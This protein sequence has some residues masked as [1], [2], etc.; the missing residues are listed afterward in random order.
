MKKKF[1]NWVRNE[2]TGSRTL[3]LN[4]QISDET[5]FGDEVTPGLFR[6]ELQSCEG[7]ITVWINSPGGDVFAAAQI[8]NMLMEYPGNVDVRID[9][10]AASAASVIAMAGNKVSMSPVAM[11]MIHN[12]ITVAMG[13]KKVM[14]QAI[15]MLDEIKES[16]IN[17]YEL[18]TGQPR[19]KIAHMMDAETWFNAKKAVELGFA[20]D[21]LYTDG[22]GKQEA[23]AA[24]LFSKIM[25]MNSFLC[26]F[27]KPES[28][29]DT[30]V[31]VEPLKKRLFLLSH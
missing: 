13:D 9:G 7:D 2:D 27:N 11:M 19:T 23:P 5:W 25:V 4:G 10:I 30:R 20:D 29:P 8:Y 21:I 15:D 6:E 22:E 12:P 16:I 28:E 1:W 17:A 31:S 24:V 26:K 14:Q 18:K 3:V